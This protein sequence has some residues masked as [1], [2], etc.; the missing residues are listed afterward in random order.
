[1]LKEE[2]PIF[3]LFQKFAKTGKNE[4]KYNVLGVNYGLNEFHLRRQLKF[5]DFG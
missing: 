2:N 4:A 5:Q 1:M 3:V